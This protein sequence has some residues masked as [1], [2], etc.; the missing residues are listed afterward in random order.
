MSKFNDRLSGISK[1][2]QQ[3]LYR[4]LAETCLE[5]YS[6]ADEQIRFIGHNAGITYHIETLRTGE[7]FL[8][9]IHHSAGDALGDPPERIRAGLLWLHDLAQQTPLIVQQPVL[10]INDDLLTTIYFHDLAEPFYCS[11]QHWV[12]GEHSRDPSSMHANAIG[13]MMGRLHHHASQWKP[14]SKLP[15][16][17]VDELSLQASID[18]VASVVDRGILSVSEWRQVKTASEKLF[19]LIK[20]VG[21]DSSVWGPIHGD[22]H[23][24][25]ILFNDVDARPIDFGGLRVGHYAYDLGVI[26]YHFMYLDVS[27]RQALLTGY[28]KVRGEIGLPPMALEAFVCAAAVDNL[29]FQ[30]MLPSQLGSP[31]LVRNVQQFANEFCDKLAHHIPF[32]LSRT[33]GM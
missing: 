9:K 18:R 26:F 10:N 17:R 6:V 23:H 8:L 11:L 30:V 24:A 21:L 7:A 1:H 5:P 32:V 16:H 22:L 33:D 28:Q 13:E 4:Q 31:L 3:R 14:A 15:A 20:T 25:N 12:E 29:A 2:Q 19:A 27:I